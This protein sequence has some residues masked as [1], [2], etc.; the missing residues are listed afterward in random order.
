MSDLTDA[1]VAAAGPDWRT[2][3]SACLVRGECPFT[4]LP[5]TECKRGPCDCDRFEDRWGARTPAE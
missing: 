2:Y 5:G 4:G 1:F 3:Q